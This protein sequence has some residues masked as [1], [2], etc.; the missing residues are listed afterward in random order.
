MVVE[1]LSQMVLEATPQ[2]PNLELSQ[3]FGTGTTHRLSPTHLNSNRQACV[4]STMCWTVHHP[5]ILA[6]AAMQPG[7]TVLAILSPAAVACP[8]V[9]TSCGS[10]QQA[11]CAASMSAQ[12]HMDISFRR[13]CCSSVHCTAAQQPRGQSTRA[14]SGC[15]R[16]G[17]RA[18]IRTQL[19]QPNNQIHTLGRAQLLA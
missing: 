14:R 2:D 15:Y 19:I 18:C 10:L 4:D 13:P 1:R 11:A 9:G 12:R 16:P 5:L 6:H 17:S 3:A 8:L 7:C